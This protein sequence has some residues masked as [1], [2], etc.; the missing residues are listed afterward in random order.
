M[1]IKVIASTLLPTKMVSNFF[2]ESSYVYL[3]V[4]GSGNRTEDEQDIFIVSC[5][6][7]A[8]LRI[9]LGLTAYSKQRKVL[10]Q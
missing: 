3:L 8:S 6:Y 4:N 10:C 1:A 9:V 7:G 5:N 2:P